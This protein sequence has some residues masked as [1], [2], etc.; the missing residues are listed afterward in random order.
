[1]KRVPI[2]Y[3]EADE[4]STLTGLCTTTAALAAVWTG[5]YFFAD[6]LVAWW[7]A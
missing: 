3:P 7:A 4:P 5:V 6:A 2:A 1:M